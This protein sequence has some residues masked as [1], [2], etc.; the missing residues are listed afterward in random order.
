[1]VTLEEKLENALQRIADGAKFNGKIYEKQP[2]K[3]NIDFSIYLDGEYV[4]LGRLH[5]SNAADYR[6]TLAEALCIS[7][8]SW[9]PT[10]SA[11]P[12]EERGNTEW[13]VDGKKVKNNL[14][15]AQMW[16]KYGTDFE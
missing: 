1:M 15:Y 7:E 5:R 11:L 10:D 3:N 13:L 4:N 8:D 12:K 6:K 2:N 9:K 16:D 14:N